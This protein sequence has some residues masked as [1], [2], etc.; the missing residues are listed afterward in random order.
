MVC[1][2]RP[3]A[4]SLQFSLASSLTR[5]NVRLRYPV[6]APIAF[7]KASECWRVV[8]RL[9]LEVKEVWKLLQLP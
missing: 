3:R 4:A 5:S 1:T 8:I 9:L 2:A 7:R 6:R